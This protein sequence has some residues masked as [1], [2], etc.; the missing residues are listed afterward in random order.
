MTK[1]SYPSTTLQPMQS[2]YFKLSNGSRV[3]ALLKPQ[4][5]ASGNQ[6]SHVD[7]DCSAAGS[8]LLMGFTSSSATWSIT[9]AGQ[10][11]YR[12]AQHEAQRAAAQIIEIQL[13]GEEFLERSDIVQIAGSGIQIVVI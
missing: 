7:L 2:I 10:E 9:Q 3:H 13:A 11:A 4:P 1:N 12:Y 5:D 8:D 6:V